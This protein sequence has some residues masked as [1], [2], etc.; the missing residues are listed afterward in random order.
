[1]RKDSAE[2]CPRLCSLEMGRAAAGFRLLRSWESYRS[3]PASVPAQPT[4][5]TCRAR[6][7][8]DLDLFGRTAR[9]I[10]NLQE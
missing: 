10:R 3:E 2:L 9:V 8:P 7:E 4:M 6:D 5:I 1:M